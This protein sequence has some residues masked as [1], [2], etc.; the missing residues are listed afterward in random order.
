METISYPGSQVPVDKPSK[1][2]LS[3]LIPCYYQF[4]N[5]LGPTQYIN[6]L[7]LRKEIAF[8]GKV[9]NRTT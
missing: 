1:N 6:F 4:R 5:A 2:A 9:G 3:K 8:P 7:E